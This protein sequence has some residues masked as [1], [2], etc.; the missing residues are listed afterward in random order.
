MNPNQYEEDRILAKERGRPFEVVTKTSRG[1][2]WQTVE[3]GI[4]DLHDA[5][6]LTHQILGNYYQVG[7][8]M[9]HET[10]GYLYWSSLDPDL[11]NSKIITMKIY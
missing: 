5:M 6:I 1:K 9:Q 11:L 8:F 3:S 10:G 2:R 4:E 7:I